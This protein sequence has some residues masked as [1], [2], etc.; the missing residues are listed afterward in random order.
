MSFDSSIESILWNHDGYFIVN[1]FNSNCC[2][3]V[4]GWIVKRE[5]IC[6]G[7]YPKTVLTIY[8]PN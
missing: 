6:F 4:E 3:E 1:C 7:F 2:V 5:V 8:R